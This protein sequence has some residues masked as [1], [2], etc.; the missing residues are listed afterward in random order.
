MYQVGETVLYGTEGVCKIEQLSEMKVG[1]EKA[2]YYVMRPIYREGSTVFV[3][4][5]NAMLLAK[6]RPLL[7]ED[8]VDDMLRRVVRDE[9]L[10]VDD[11]AERKTQFQHILVSGDRY[12]MLRMLRALYLRRKK[13]QSSGK[14]M[15]M[16]DEQL[17]RDAEKL[18]NDEFAVVL[19]IR[20][21]EV[22]E[23]V[24]SRMGD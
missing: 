5:D 21:R 9:T 22:P 1:K 23:Y 20:R 17:M 4:T 12:A 2:V 18:L 11:A 6:I 15:R 10:W 3:P 16:S 19:G 24:R 8:E 13:L 7:T 14:R